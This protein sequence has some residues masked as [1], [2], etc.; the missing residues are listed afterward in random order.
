MKKGL[1][2]VWM[3]L[4]SGGMLFS[5]TIMQP[6]P[7]M[8]SSQNGRYYF[9]MQPGVKRP[10]KDAVGIMYQVKRKG[11]DKELWRVTGWYTY[12]TYPSFRGQ[13]LVR[14]GMLHEAYRVSKPRLAIA[15][16]E[17]GKL[18]KKYTTKDLQQAVHAKRKRRHYGTWSIKKVIGFNDWGHRFTII[19]RDNVRYVFNAKDGSLVKAEQVK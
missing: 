5:L 9:R 3:I 19:S 8:V 14:L 7:Y 18:M 13:Y 16:Y 12:R 10:W 4:G 6:Y 11:P 2:L 17:K 1:I 15:F